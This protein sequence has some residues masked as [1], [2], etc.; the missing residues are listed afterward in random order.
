MAEA[1]GIRETVGVSE[2]EIPAPSLALLGTTVSGSYY[3]IRPYAYNQYELLI[4]L[5]NGRE[6]ARR[7]L[8]IEDSELFYKTLSLSE[9][10]VLSGLLCFRDKAK[11]VSWRSDKLTEEKAN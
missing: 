1:G 8:T 5:E 4:L 3:F 6:A 10:G 2:R 11:V 9:Q 7:F